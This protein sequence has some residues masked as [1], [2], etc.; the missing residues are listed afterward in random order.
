M[1]FNILVVD[2][3]ETMR[4]V[5]K[6]T[7][8]MTG[9]GVGELLEAGNGKEALEVLADSWIDIVLSD[10]N[11]PEMGGIE[12]L[13]AMKGDD[14]LRN[15]PVIFISTESSH[16]R[17][18]EAKELGV[19]AYVKKPFMPETIK[20]TMLEVLSKAYASRMDEIIEE[21]GGSDWSDDETD[22]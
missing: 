7:I 8:G 9:I 13:K 4:T 21:E 6:R 22:F 10:I 17:M 11:M 3:S 18:D 14:V 2:D 5:I 12:L 15:I 16:G 19:A 20:A 1:A